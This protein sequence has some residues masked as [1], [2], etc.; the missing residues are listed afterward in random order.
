MRSRMASSSAPP[1][2]PA[3]VHMASTL[4]SAPLVIRVHAPVASAATTDRHLRLKSYGISSI[5]C[6]DFRSTPA[7]FAAASTA[8]SSALAS[9]DW[10]CALMP[11]RR[12]TASLGWPSTSI[13]PSSCTTPAVSVPVLSVHS[14]SMLPRFSIEFSRRTITPSFAMR[15]APCDRVMLTMAGSSSGV[16]PTASARANSSEAMAGRSRKMLTASTTSTITSITRVS[17]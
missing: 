5:L 15:L 9:P 6:T 3:L 4:S 17:R 7:F 2:A 11:A 12:S 14:T 8:S 1:C 13:A 10:N 16:R